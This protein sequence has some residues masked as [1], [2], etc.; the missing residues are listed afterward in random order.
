MDNDPPVTRGALHGDHRCAPRPGAMTTKASAPAVGG[1]PNLGLSK[2]DDTRD[3]LH[4]WTQVAGKV[5]LALSP[6]LN[7][8]WHVTLS[9]SARGSRPRSCPSVAAVWRSS[10]TSWTTCST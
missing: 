5:R 10:S 2:W 4:M 9:V 8:W 7:H 3:T 6:M 1:L